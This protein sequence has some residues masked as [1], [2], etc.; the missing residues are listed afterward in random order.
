MGNVLIYKGEPLSIKI[1]VSL[2]P[3][4]LTTV[5]IISVSLN[6]MCY[7][8][9]II[10][11]QLNNFIVTY[12]IIKH[13]IYTIC[14]MLQRGCWAMGNIYLSTPALFVLVYMSR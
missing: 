5:V 4:L 8:L 7:S 10:W 9:F 1:F 13:S 12:T 14:C 2:L 11:F 6:Y 3:P